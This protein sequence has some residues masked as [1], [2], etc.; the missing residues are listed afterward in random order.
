MA[1]A[2]LVGAACGLRTD[3]GSGGTG[4]GGAAC[5]ETETDGAAPAGSCMNPFPVAY[6]HGERITGT[7]DGCSEGESW[8]GGS[9]G[10]D[11]YK[12]V[13]HRGDVKI[14]FNPV[15]GG[16]EPVLRVIRVPAGGSPCGND[17]TVEIGR[18]H[19]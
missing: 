7:I 10:E 6:Q 2:F 17:I 11:Y 13:P 5:L 4:V 16:V 8:C 1:G 12:Y 9:G 15:A 18:A 14:T 3:P 19:V